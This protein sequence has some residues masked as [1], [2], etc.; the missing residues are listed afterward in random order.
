MQIG[1]VVEIV[2]WKGAK[3]DNRKYGT[4]TRIHGK[5]RWSIDKQMKRSNCLQKD[6]LAEVL[7]QDGCTGW[8]LSSRL[9][10]ISI[11]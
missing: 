9:A 3:P 10:E 4:I 1:N 8:V 11:D 6:V 7:W 2:D 5:H